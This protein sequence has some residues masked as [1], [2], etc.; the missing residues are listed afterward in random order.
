[1]TS[2]PWVGVKGWGHALTVY[3]DDAEDEEE[4]E[5]DGGKRS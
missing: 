2:L 3:A 1:M 5:E 4:E